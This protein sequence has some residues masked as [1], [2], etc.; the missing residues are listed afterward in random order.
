KKGDFVYIVGEKKAKARVDTAYK[1]DT[2]KNMIR[3]DK[4][5]REK[6]GIRFKDKIKIEKVEEDEE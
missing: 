4:K 2:G 5:L 6:T 3:I 1:E